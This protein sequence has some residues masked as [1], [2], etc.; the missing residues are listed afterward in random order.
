MTKAQSLIRVTLA[1]VVAVAVGALWLYVGPGTGHLWLDSLI[2]DVLATVV[3]FGFSRAYHNSSFYDPFWSVVP[4]LLAF[5]WWAEGEPGGNQT[6]IVLVV[7]VIL[8]WAVRLTGNWV[9]GFP[10]LHHED[11]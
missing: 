3:V 6:R 5:Y 7:A 10:G 8:V 1:Y 11:W 4:P 9:R 2:A